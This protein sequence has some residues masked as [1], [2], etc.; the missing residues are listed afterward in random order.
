MTA[1][2]S[3]LFLSQIALVTTTVGSAADANR[4]AQGAVHATLAACAQVEAITSHYVWDGQLEHSSE[5]RIVF[6]TQPDAVQALWT[7]LKAQHPYDVPQLLLR[8]E[9]AEPSYAAWVADN[10]NLEK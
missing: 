7:W 8:T 5:W 2:D 9:H 4:L 6:K 1:M 3:S 10:V